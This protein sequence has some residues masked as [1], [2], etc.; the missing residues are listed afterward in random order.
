ME[1]NTA[2]GSSFVFIITGRMP[3]LRQVLVI[4]FVLFSSNSFQA[5]LNFGDEDG[6]VIVKPLSR[7]SKGTVPSEG[8]SSSSLSFMLIAI[9]SCFCDKVINGFSQPPL[10]KSEKTKTKDRLRS[11][12]PAPVKAFPKIEPLSLF[13]ESLCQT[14][15]RS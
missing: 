13:S 2:R 3:C 10:L 4:C 15:V 9:T 5:F 8:S 12:L 6:N 1:F 7:S 11:S 14:Q